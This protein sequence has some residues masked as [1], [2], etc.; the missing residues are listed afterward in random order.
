MR[1]LIIRHSESESNIKRTESIESG[2]EGD[3]IMSNSIE[4]GITEKGKEQSRRLGKCNFSN[5]SFIFFF[6]VP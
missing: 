6:P 2:N 5:I 4:Y 1:L 3:F